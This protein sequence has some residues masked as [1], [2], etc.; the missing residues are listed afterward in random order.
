ML[1]P[2]ERAC[3][4]LHDGVNKLIQ[5]SVFVTNHEGKKKCPQ[6]GDQPGTSPL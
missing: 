1:V 3:S 5:L 2:K 4:K 6:I